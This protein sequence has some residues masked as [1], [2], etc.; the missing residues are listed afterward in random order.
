MITVRKLNPANKALEHNAAGVGS[1]GVSVAFIALFFFGGVA[2][3]FV[4]G[5]RFPRWC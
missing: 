2:Q 5:L 3:L 1:F 4:F